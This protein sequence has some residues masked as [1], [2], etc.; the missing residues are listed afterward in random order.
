MVMTAAAI[1]E[2]GLRKIG[3]TSPFD[4][5]PEPEEFDEGLEQLD[6]LMAHLVATEIL[7]FFV[8][9]TQSFTLT[10]GTQSYALNDYLTTNLQVVRE[11]WI[12][13]S[14]GNRNPLELIR[15]SQFDTENDTTD[16]G[17]RPDRLY[18]TR[19]ADPT[20]YVLPPS[21]TETG[22]K[23]FLRGQSYSNDLT[24]E[25]GITEH[26]LEKAWELMLVY[27][28]AYELG[29]GPIT[30]LPKQERDE[31]RSVGNEYMLALQTMVGR[32]NV[33]IPRHTAM[34]EF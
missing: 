18:I 29:S 20:A 3:N 8:P 24:L 28:L 4:V 5:S 31:I 11:A 13:D 25:N 23:I 27:K 12:Q 2:K 17:T 15:R 32:E 34:R 33:R 9:V 14:N 1:V 21:F 6:M 16:T 30:T 22:L 7:W 10:V 19:T 26:G